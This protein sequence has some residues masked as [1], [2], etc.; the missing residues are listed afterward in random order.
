M[1]GEDW[2]NEATA[3]LFDAIVSLTGRDE[4]AHF[5]RDLCTRRE[6]E[7]ISQRWAVVRKLAAGH[8]YR[9]ISGE[10]G[11]STATIVRINQWLRHGTGGYQHMLDKLNLGQEE[12]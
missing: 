9:E 7:E 3:A 1:A 11:V 6:L 12:Q 2:R 5:F 4:A 10:T 8:S